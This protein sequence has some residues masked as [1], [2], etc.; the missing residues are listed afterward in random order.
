MPH[1]RFELDGPPGEGLYVTFDDRS[2]PVDS[3]DKKFSV[4]PGAHRVKAYARRDGRVVEY[5]EH[6]TIRE[7]EE[8]VVGLRL[9]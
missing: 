7:A 6:V 2:V 5:E 9:N 3:L 1:L 4:N 8:V